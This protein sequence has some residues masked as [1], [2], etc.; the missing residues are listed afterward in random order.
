MQVAVWSKKKMQVAA[1]A[2]LG[3]DSSIQSVRIGTQHEGIRIREI[4]LNETRPQ[5]LHKSAAE[6]YL[7]ISNQEIE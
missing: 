5:E 7:F 6:S 4:Q 3:L 1:V 2:F